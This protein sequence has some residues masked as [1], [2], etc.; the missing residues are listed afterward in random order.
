[1]SRLSLVLSTLALILAAI[2]VANP[3]LRD[4]APALDRAA[5]EQ[6]ARDVVA[7]EARAQAPAS[8]PVAADA[9]ADSASDTDGETSVASADPATI[10]PAVRQYLLDNPEVLEEV[11][12]ALE[13]KRD[14][15]QADQQKDA[16]ASNRDTL[17]KPDFTNAVGNPDGDVTLVEFF[18]YNCGYCKQMLPQIVD[19]IEKDK[20]LRV[21]FREWPVLG[22]D[23]QA[24]ARV[25]M[26]VRQVAPD[27]YFEFHQKLLSHR[28][29]V[30]KDE[31]MEVAKELGIDTAAVEQKMGED[32][33][34]AALQENFKLGDALGLRGTPS[35]VVGDKVFM[36][37]VPQD[38]IESQIAQVRG[39]DCTN[40]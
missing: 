40:C 26:G 38:Q 23:S 12:T 16:V 30:G 8:E 10:G 31:A 37:A 36:G 24:A 15:A 22:E 19:L 18:D 9:S 1:M 17:L 25:A 34:T 28:G 13:A 7:E 14:Q 39:S 33:T 2:A 32:Q 6:V 27:S 4:T 5:V 3:Y 21:V 20:N 29:R 11:I 35:Y